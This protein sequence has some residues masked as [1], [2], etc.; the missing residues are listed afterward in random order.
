V[1]ADPQPFSY[2]I[3]PGS[4][5]TIVRLKGELDM[6]ASPALRDVLGELQGSGAGEIVIDLRGL[7]F[8][9]S[10]G[11]SALVEAHV[12]G[13]DGQRKVAFIKG[14]R[15]VQRVFSVTEM[16]KRVT[17]TDP[18]R[19]AAQGVGRGA[20]T[21]EGA[22]EGAE[23]ETNMNPEPGDNEAPTPEQQR[24]GQQGEETPQPTSPEPDDE[25]TPEA[26]S[27]GE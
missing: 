14:G 24:G 26:Q 6:A 23:M 11:L 22:E 25:V 18:F 19:S 9:D 5:A 17:W 4:D 2:R 16:D 21:I 15:S 3:E 12:A 20:S 27:I 13:Q 7:C 1:I 8:L 10:M